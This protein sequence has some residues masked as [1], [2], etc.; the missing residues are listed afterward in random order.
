MLI[1]YSYSSFMWMTAF[2]RRIFSIGCPHTSGILSASTSKTRTAAAYDATTSSYLGPRGIANPAGIEA[3]LSIVGRGQVTGTESIL[4]GRVW[5]LR[6]C[7]WTSIWEG[8]SLTPC[9]TRQAA[10]VVRVASQASRL[11]TLVCW[12]VCFRVHG[13]A[14]M[15][16]D[17]TAL[18]PSLPHSMVPLGPVR[19]LA[20]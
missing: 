5:S 11:V 8:L 15:G 12:I 6:P 7:D 14:W 1:D 19:C 20:P 10:V 17:L 9:Q 13:W 16:M 18:Y 3:C 4:S 2:G